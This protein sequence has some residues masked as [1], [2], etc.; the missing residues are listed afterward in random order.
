[1]MSEVGTSHRPSCSPPA[2]TSV[3]LR[4]AIGRTILSTAAGSGASVLRLAIAWMVLFA[5]VGCGSTSAYRIEKHPDARAPNGGYP[6]DIDLLVWPDTDREPPAT[7]VWWGGG[8]NQELPT[9]A[10]CYTHLDISTRGGVSEA[11]PPKGELAP[12]VLVEQL[13]GGLL[14]VY[15]RYQDKRD[16]A[17]DRNMG[18]D[19]GREVVKSGELGEAGWVRILLGDD[20]VT[21]KVTHKDP[22][23]WS[24]F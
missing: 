11:I 2:G 7:D 14:V 13:D 24:L 23:R 12:E 8:R 1:M 21:L 22:P 10:E 5:V 4:S 16:A 19:M 18:R 17:N 9:R 15:W 20:E 6:V 3:A